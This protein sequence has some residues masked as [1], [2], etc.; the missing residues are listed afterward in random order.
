LKT[1]AIPYT[2]GSSI[3]CPH[4]LSAIK[5]ERIDPLTLA[6]HFYLVEMHSK[7][8]ANIVHPCKDKSEW[9]KMNGPTILPPLYQKHVGRP[10]KNRRKAPGE[11]DYRGGWKKMSRRGVIMHCSYCGTPDH[12]INGC[13]WF[14]NGLTPP[15]P[16][17]LNMSAPTA[18]EPAPVVTPAET[19]QQQADVPTYTDTFVDR[20]VVVPCLIKRQ[21]S[22]VS[23]PFPGSVDSTTVQNK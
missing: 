21:N 6:D 17:L 12:N 16:V 9:E 20:I 3:P 13:Y 14:K 7:A 19:V 8:Y 2:C 5:D 23:V 4:V 11:V 15:D 1:V 10:T 18:E 22:C